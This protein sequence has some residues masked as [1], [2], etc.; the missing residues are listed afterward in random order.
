MV[1]Q[2]AVKKTPILMPS[3]QIG[4]ITLSID[5][6]QKQ[7]ELVI[8]GHNV[9]TLLNPNIRAFD[10][11][12]SFMYFKKIKKIKVLQMLIWLVK[13]ISTEAVIR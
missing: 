9:S 10:E 6:P 2:N 3:I 5:S 12:F 1:V 8:I 4:I 11:C 13:S 7:F